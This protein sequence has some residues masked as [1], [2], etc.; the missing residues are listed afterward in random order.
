MRALKNY[1]GSSIGRKQLMGITGIVWY[2]FLLVHLLG[3]VGLLAGP[4]RFNTYGHMLLS[5]LAEFIIPTEII[6]VAA[7]V[8]HIVLAIKLRGENKA[9][10]PVAYAVTPNQGK[11][12]AASSTMMVTGTFIA[13]YI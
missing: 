6:L 4:E 5:D 12:T 11:R 7:I 9:A 3:N 1:L 10:R 2:L 8:M 13:L